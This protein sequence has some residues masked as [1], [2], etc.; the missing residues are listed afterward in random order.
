MKKHALILSILL[1]SVFG[2]KISSA[3]TI[4]E[5]V[6]FH[7]FARV[8][9]CG[10]YTPGCEFWAIKCD[11]YGSEICFAEDQIP[12]EEGCEENTNQ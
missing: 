3:S 12:C 11:Y 4:K 1:T 10:A 5:N 6:E 8:D 9:E 2:Y 7:Y